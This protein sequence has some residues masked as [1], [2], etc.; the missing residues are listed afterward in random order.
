MVSYAVR[1]CDKHW[2]VRAGVRYK[3]GCFFFLFFLSS[4][5]HA[6]RRTT[7]SCMFPYPSLTQTCTT[8][9]Y[10]VTFAKMAKPL[11]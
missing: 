3:R 10:G 7:P 6:R 5:V 1:S 11:L 9:L 2:S 8:N 4:F